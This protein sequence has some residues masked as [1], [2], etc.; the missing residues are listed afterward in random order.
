MGLDVFISYSSM[1]KNQIEVIAGKLE[2]AGISCWYAPR[3]IMPGQ[4]WVG[5]INAAIEEAK[6]FLLVYTKNSNAS[7]QVHNEV[8]L[9]FNENKIMIPFRLSEAGMSSEIKYYLTRVHWLDCVDVSF[10][11]ATEQL[12]E[13]IASALRGEVR[14]TSG[15]E[16]AQKALAKEEKTGNPQNG[17][18]LKWIIAILAGA[19]LLAMAFFAGPWRQSKASEYQQGIKLWKVGELSEART[20]LEKAADKDMALAELALATMQ[21]DLLLKQKPSGMSSQDLATAGEQLRSLGEELISSGCTEANYLLGVYY[22]EAFEGVMD[23]E[24][25]IT[26]FEKALQGEETEWLLRSYGYLCMLYGTAEGMSSNAERVARYAGKAEEIL[27]QDGAQDADKDTESAYNAWPAYGFSCE[28]IGDGFRNLGEGE[29]AFGWYQR[30][31]NAGMAASMNQLGLAY[32]WGDGTQEDQEL[33]R[34]W[35][36]KAAD[37]GDKNAIKN[38]EFLE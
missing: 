30:A 35:F 36:Q 31:A 19:A 20:S 9:A 26:Y 27:S 8:A 11:Q 3:N 15:A 25:A 12:Q 33:A 16:D 1:D 29:K 14:F 22:A 21:A 10:E 38:L 37:A 4:E 34:K 32:L 17:S 28:R 18:T 5:A 13:Y 2:A 6:I 23:R 24:K 7:R